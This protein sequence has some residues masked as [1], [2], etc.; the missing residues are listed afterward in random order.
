MEWLCCPPIFIVFRI[1]TSK[2][3][4]TLIK[5]AGIKKKFKPSDFLEALDSLRQLKQ[6][7][8]LSKGDID[9]VDTLT[10]EL[11]NDL[12]ETVK[13]RVGTI[14]LPDSKAVLCNSE[15]LTIPESFEVKYLEC[16]RYIHDGIRRGHRPQA[17][18]EAIAYKKKGKVW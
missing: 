2:I 9:L 13:E 18:S 3:I 11:K 12:D 4:K 17:W 8:H 1:S 14:P 5:L 7:S 15:D 6:D 10:K 16:E